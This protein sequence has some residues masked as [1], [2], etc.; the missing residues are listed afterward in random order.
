[1]LT[2]QHLRSAA[3]HAYHI[4]LDGT[5]PGAGAEVGPPV[6]YTAP[7]QA[8]SAGDFGIDA[9]FVAPVADG[10]VIAI[11]GTTSPLDPTEPVQKVL[12]DWIQNAGSLL[13]TAGGDP[14]GFPGRVH[15]GFYQAFTKIWA[16]LWPLVD[17]AVA[18]HPK[19]AIFLTG[20]SKG[21]SVCPLI[22]W[23]LRKDFPEHQ[24]RVRT[25]GASRCGDP[26]FAAAYNAVVDH[27]RYEYDEDLVPHLPGQNHLAGMLGATTPVTAFLSTVDPGYGDVGTLG[28]INTAGNIVGGPAAS[29]VVR[30]TLL[31]A[32]LMTTGGA[33]YVFA[34]H[35]ITAASDGYVR[36]N[37]P[38]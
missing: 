7:P 38:D 15:F 25:F 33:G 30:A 1:M 23:R 9:G 6:G 12:L 36:A 27:V 28:Y 37:Y 21:G 24:I 20:H 29:E 10:V 32:R 13:V 17:A 35:G 18:A 4:A 34:C 19:K 26:T 31:A 16:K 8:V 3:R 22:A 5:V 11:R 2:T 14:P